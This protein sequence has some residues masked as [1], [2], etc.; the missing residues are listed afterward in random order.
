MSAGESPPT[1]SCISWY[2]PPHSPSHYNCSITVPCP[3]KARTYK[4]NIS[5]RERT[6]KFNG[7]FVDVFLLPL[8]PNFFCLALRDY[9]PW[10]VVVNHN[11][12]HILWVIVVLPKLYSIWPFWIKLEC[13]TCLVQKFSVF[14]LQCKC[15]R[16]NQSSAFKLKLFRVLWMETSFDGNRS[17]NHVLLCEPLRV[18]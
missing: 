10:S 14:S 3:C 15:Q 6:V 4:L 17:S 18:E 1:S 11:L 13:L 2:L 7:S 8:L 9:L 12:L 16:Y 5:S